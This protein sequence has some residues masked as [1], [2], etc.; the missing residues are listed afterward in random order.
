MNAAVRTDAFLD[1]LGTLLIVEDEVLIRLDLADQLRLVGFKVIEASTGDEALTVLKS[2]DEI[3]VVISDIRMP[4][5]TDGTTLAA[6]LRREMPRI[7]IV[8]MS[9]HLPTAHMS[10]IA[11]LAFEKPVDPAF[12]ARRVKELLEDEQG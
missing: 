7:K 6:W 5:Q 4:G 12:L 3:S 8:L 11:D 10:A 9:G 1:G 2:V